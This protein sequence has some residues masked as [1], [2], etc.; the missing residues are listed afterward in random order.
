ME[1]TRIPYLVIPWLI[2]SVIAL[3]TAVI[4]LYG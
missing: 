4:M 1:L 3:I 2:G